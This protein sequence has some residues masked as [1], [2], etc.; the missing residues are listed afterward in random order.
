MKLVE[1]GVLGEI[2]GFV[3]WIVVVWY[4]LVLDVLGVYGELGDFVGFWGKMVD[5][6]GYVLGVE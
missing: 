2:I 1:V 5:Y 4:G 3:E 6:V